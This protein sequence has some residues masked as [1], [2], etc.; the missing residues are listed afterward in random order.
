MVA[1]TC[2]EVGTIER[3]IMNGIRGK[4]KACFVHGGLMDNLFAK[5]EL[6]HLPDCMKMIR[7]HGMPAGI[8]G[9]NPQVHLWARDNLD[10]DFHMCSYYNPTSRVNRPDYVPGQ[11]EKYD[12]A[13]RALM[14]ETIPK[15]HKPVIHYKVMGAGRNDP[16]EALGVVGSCSRAND[17]VC[18]GIYTKDRPDEIAQDIA[19]VEELVQPAARERQ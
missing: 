4:A 9:H 13:D 2:P 10:I 14:V 18:V 7:D 1:Q 15:L 3:G 8:A 6:D 19:L 17:A 11:T 12:H 16:R 5:G